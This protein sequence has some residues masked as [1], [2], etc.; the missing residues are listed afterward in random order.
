MAAAPM[1][2]P[3]CPALAFCTASTER[4]RMVLMHKFSRSRSGIG[5]N[6]PPAA[7]ITREHFGGGVMARPLFDHIRTLEQTGIAHHGGVEQRLATG[8][9]LETEIGA[10]AFEHT[11]GQV[12]LSP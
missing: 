2:M 11:K 12:L 7:A 9:I 1:G 3:G 4:M 10:L 6:V 5:F 8:P